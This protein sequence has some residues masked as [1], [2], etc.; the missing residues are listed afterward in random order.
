MGQTITGNTTKR[1]EESNLIKNL[2]LF[3]DDTLLN[4]L[5]FGLILSAIIFFVLSVCFLC[6]I[7][8]DCGNRSKR[9]IKTGKVKTRD[10]DADQNNNI[11]IRN[12][13]MKYRSE[14]L[15]DSVEPKSGLTK[16]SKSPFKSKAIESKASSQHSSAIESRLETKQS[17]HFVPKVD[18]SPT[19]LVKLYSPSTEEGKKIFASSVDDEN[20]VK[21]SRTQSTGESTMSS[22]ISSKESQKLI[23][24]QEPSDYKEYE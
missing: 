12:N 6:I 21:R 24:L 22:A 4:L 1:S 14:T 2:K 18:S 7:C 23:K 15:P 8:F 5:F 20:G 19:G 16:R 9:A 10:M 13:N 11:E 3:G 17:S